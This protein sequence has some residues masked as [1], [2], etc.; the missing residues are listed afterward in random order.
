MNNTC[1][2]SL[3]SNLLLSRLLQQTKTL[4]TYYYPYIPKT[5]FSKP[6]KPSAD[7]SIEMCSLPLTEKIEFTFPS[8]PP[9]PMGAVGR[10]ADNPNTGFFFFFLSCSCLKKCQI[11]FSSQNE[12]PRS[13]LKADVTNDPSWV[14]NFRKNEWK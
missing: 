4:K 6:S 2:F 14:R 12:R 11:H 8:V 9:D 13:R 3:N 1:I 10:T 7:S 5:R